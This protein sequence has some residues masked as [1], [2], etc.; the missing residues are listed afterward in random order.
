[1]RVL[2]LFINA[3]I[4]G[5]YFACLLSLLVADLNINRAFSPVHL[6]GLAAYLMLSYGLLATLACFL[7]ALGYGFIT[8]RKTATTAVSP[9]F[10]SLSLP[11]LTLLAL[12]IIRENYI[13]FRSFDVP[14]VQSLIQAQIAVLFVMAVVSLVLRYRHIHRRPR[15][16]TWPVFGTLAAVALVVT[17]AL[18]LYFPQSQKP[19]PW[20]SLEVKPIDREVTVLRFEGLNLNTILSLTAE[21]KLPNFQWLMERGS[22]GRIAGLTPSEP[23]VLN[24]CFDTGKLPGK[25]R[26]ISDVRYTIPTLPFPLEVVPR[27]ILFRQ[28]KR[29]G[30]LTVEPQEAPLRAKDLVTIFTDCGA[31]VVHHDRPA[32]GPEPVQ[33]NPKSEKLFATFYPDRS[34]ETSWIFSQVRRAF[35][36]DAKA[37]EAAL[38]SKAGA[39][40]LFLLGLDGVT[41]VQTY[42]TKYSEPAAFGDL[43]QDEIQKYGTVIEKFYE[44]YDGILGAYLA[45]LKE[46]ELFIV[47]SSFGSE[48]LPFWKRVVEWILGNAAVTAYHEHAPDGV[49][50]FYGQD[51]QR[52]RN[53]GVIRLIDLAPTILYYVGLPVGK[54]MDGVVRG[55]LFDPAFT[56][57]NP[58]L[59]ITSYE[60]VTVRRPAK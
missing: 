15:P 34:S 29:I 1:M 60:D 18:R 28:L 23:I 6:G 41:S 58:L 53:A 52:G 44:F 37:Q 35:A 56:A 26:R 31:S 22:W 3:L 48:P 10:L 4:S 43:R 50:F 9:S 55:S 13:Y 49:V 25:H 5:L 19:V 46:D 11:L 51:I 16:F 8:G 12:V 20:T 38:P 2:R 27:F 36:R 40:G 21:K 42:F 30:L 24:A 54:D 32:A 33:P 14:L 57:E 45:T 17:A 39:P 7:S 59:T 47:Y